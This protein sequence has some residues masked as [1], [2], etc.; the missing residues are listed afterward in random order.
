MSFMSLAS[1]QLAGPLQLEV[2][3]DDVVTVA[4]VQHL[5]VP[6]LLHLPSRGRPLRRGGSRGIRGFRVMKLTAPESAASAAGL[7]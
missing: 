1:Q 3:V 2:T 7:L 4:A 6:V 5:L